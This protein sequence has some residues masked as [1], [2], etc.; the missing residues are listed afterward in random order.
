VKREHEQAA[1]QAMSGD[2][3]QGPILRTLLVFSI[4][5]LFANLLQ[6]MGST[7]NTIWVGQ[8]LGQSALA[9]TVNANIVVFLAF[10]A[11]YGFGMATTVMVG[12]HFGARHLDAAR[13][14]FGSGVGFCTAAALVGAVLGW[15]FADRVLRLL[16]TPESIQADAL[17]YLQVSFLSM[18]FTTAAMIISMGLRGAGDA[19]TPLY[20]MII[21]T[22]LGIALNPLLILGLGPM[23]E[24]GIAGSALANALAALGGAVAMVAWAYWKDLPLRLK[25]RELVYL[26]PRSDELRYVLVKGLPMGAQMLIATAAAV[27]MVGFVNREGM[28]TA[29]AYGAVIQM[30]NFI[31]MPAFAIS[32]A[33]SAMV[34]QNIGAALHD[35]VGR[36]TTVGILANTAITLG[37]TVGLILFDRPMLALFLGN[38]Q[39]TIEIA[40][41]IQLVATWSWVFA[42]VMMVVSGTMRSYGVVVLPLVIMI[43]SQYAARIGF[44]HLTYPTLGVDAIWWSYNFSALVAMVLTWLAYLHGPW[45]KSQIPAAALS[46]S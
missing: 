17:A 41:H 3:T 44:Y 2:L 39:E 27:I 13:R 11:V 6:T 45:R 25:G 8:L 7:I 40:A 22:I 4:P 5:T 34:A 35:R 26:I 12:Q 29:A 28:V 16:S 21:T 30:W 37:L 15:F 9:A 10:A 23:P 36:I 18:P 20:A 31:Q 33:I 19:K 42:G 1:A 46:T 43:I 14:T 32:T 38:S 24:L